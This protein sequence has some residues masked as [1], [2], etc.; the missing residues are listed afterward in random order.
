M[1]KA[2][3]FQLMNCFM[4]LKKEDIVDD[5]VCFF[6]FLTLKK[7]LKICK[8][9]KPTRHEH[10]TRRDAMSLTFKSPKQRELVMVI[11]PRETGRFYQLVKQKFEEN[12]MADRVILSPEMFVGDVMWVVK[13]TEGKLMAGNN[14]SSNNMNAMKD[15]VMYGFVVEVKKNNDWSAS[16]IDSRLKEQRG[17]FFTLD[18]NH[19]KFFYILEGDVMQNHHGIRPEASI[20]AMISTIM[21]DGCKI[22]NTQD[23]K[24]TANL[25]MMLHLGLEQYKEPADSRG[26]LSYTHYIQPLAKKRDVAE[27]Y[28]LQGFLINHVPGVSPYI[29]DA[30]AERYK[31]LPGLVLALIKSRSNTQT[32]IAGMEVDRGTGLK[33]RCIG[34]AVATAIDRIIGT[35]ELLAG[36]ALKK[37]DSPQRSN[38]VAAAS[39][40][41]KAKNRKRK[42]EE[43]EEEAEDNND[44]DDDDEDEEDKDDDDSA[45]SSSEVATLPAKRSGH[46]KGKAAERVDSHFSPSKKPKQKHLMK[47]VEGRNDK[48]DADNGDPIMDADDLIIDVDDDPIEL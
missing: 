1:K 44:D 42:R 9:N 17:R 2:L 5:S 29:A 16:V 48:K 40:A 6:L 18:T 22:G 30:I 15:P 11:D 41:A 46:A 12:G 7:K 45:K 28:L 23:G 24:G 35:E 36:L 4:S 38:V 37:L 13:G 34:P 31:T 47:R 26:S 14:N 21:N 33:P 19:A 10:E 8:K 39:A 32:T 27:K 20:G 25:L 43:E 3:K